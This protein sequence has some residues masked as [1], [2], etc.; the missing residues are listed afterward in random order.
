M[1]ERMTEDEARRLID[2]LPPA[3]GD[4]VTAVMRRGWAPSV[5]FIMDMEEGAGRRMTS[6]E[7]DVITT[8]DA[9]V[10][11]LTEDEARRLI[12]DLLPTTDGDRIATARRNSYVFGQLLMS[13]E[14]KAGR[15]M[16]PK[17]ADALTSEMAAV[18]WL[19]ARKSVAKNDDG[20]K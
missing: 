5:G 1:G 20:E 15:F 12:E 13:L 10:G 3:D 17:E 6:K 14:Q 2:G 9:A 16:T 8:E 11:W 7:W 19:T 18:W 4:R